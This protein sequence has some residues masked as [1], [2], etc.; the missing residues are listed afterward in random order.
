MSIFKKQ[1]P[2][3]EASDES[4][5]FSCLGGDQEAFRII[6]TRYQN[7]LCSLAYSSVG[8]IKCSEDIA[9][10]TFIEAWKKLDSLREPAKLKAWLCGILRYKASRHRR[11]EGKQ[12]ASDAVEIAESNEP[13][14]NRS[15]M[16]NNVIEQQEQVLLWKTLDKM[17]DTYREPL[18]LF[19]R[20]HQSVER[21]AEELDISLD[22]AKQRLSRGRK[23]LK[24]AMITFVEDSLTKSKPG[25]GFTAAVMLSISVITPPA[26][27][28]VLGAGAVKGSSYFKLASVLAFVATFSGLISSFFGLKA[29]LA[30]SRTE[31]ERQNVIKVVAI[32][33]GVAAIF[34]GG[35]FLFKYI[36]FSTQNNSL[37]IGAIAQLWVITF[38]LTYTF[39]VIR[40]TSQLMKMRAQERLLQP[41]AFERE[42]DN[43]KSGLREYKSALTLFGVPLFHFQFGMPEEGDGPAY[44]WI[45]GGSQAYG[46]VFAWGGFAVAPISVGIVAVGAFSVGAVGVGLIGLGTV[47]MGLIGF[48]SS[49]IAY[50][51]Y[52]ALSALGWESAFSSGFSM[53]KS[54]AIGPIA[55][56][57][58][59]NNELAAEI[60]N[61]AM[62][63]ISYQWALG[64]IALLVLVPAIWHSRKVRQRMKS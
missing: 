51:A 23:L 10:E 26:K 2:I 49:A 38:V 3:T 60:A 62:F 14:P 36:A 13:E 6:V 34:V 27:A 28:A 42:S 52:G 22:T 37:L 29:G 8:N 61:L 16:E 20:E 19:Y 55:H 35:L 56:A 44:G 30:Q 58:Y 57:T 63:S 45:S 31:K 59:V 18:I 21:V 54:A 7:L 50:K 48:G 39:L 40:L 46:L 25:V 43:K 24:Q 32:F 1:I 11:S 5:V 64:A 53:A 9:Q 17:A 12:P 47:G 33:I 4:L 41:E 15:E